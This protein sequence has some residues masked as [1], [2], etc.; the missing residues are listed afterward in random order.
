MNYGDEAWF[1]KRD[2]R[3][4]SIIARDRDLDCADLV[5][6]CIDEHNADARFQF[7][8]LT[9]A[10]Y[11][12]LPGAQEYGHAS[13][14][15]MA[16]MWM[17]PSQWAVVLANAFTTSWDASHKTNWLGMKYFDFTVLGDYAMLEI[18]TQGLQRHEDNATSVWIV[19]TLKVVRSYLPA[20]CLLQV[21]QHI[22][23]RAGSP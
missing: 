21:M 5:S 12:K 6:A 14:D 17:H 1:T 2:V 4:A 9:Y 13:E 3:N 20:T 22:C 8:V 19:E 16:I 11:C 15:L 23:C 18:I 10:D 7:K